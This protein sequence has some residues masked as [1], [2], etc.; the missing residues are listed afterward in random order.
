MRRKS[1][2]N[3]NLSKNN[4]KHQ[5]KI[6]MAKLKL[7][8]TAITD[9]G[10]IRKNNEDNFVV[11]QD[12]TGGNWF[13]PQADAAPFELGKFGSLMVVAD[14]MGGMNAGEVASDIAV[15]TVQEYF[16]ADKLSKEL[17]DDATAVNNYLKQVIMEADNRI[18][19]RSKSDP[20]TEGMGTTI[21]ITWIIGDMA[22]VAWCGDS[23]AYSYHPNSGLRQL[24]KDHSY[25]QELVDSGKL[26]PELAFD[27]PDGNIITSSLGDMS[28]PAAPDVV[29][30]ELHEGEIIL[31]C[32]D[33]LCGM[34]RDS[35]MLQVLDA[36]Y[37]DLTL[38]KKTL[39]DGALAAGGHDNVTL[40][41]TLVVK[42]GGKMP[43]TRDAD[44]AGAVNLPARPNRMKSLIAGGIIL[45]LLAIIGV[46][47]L[48][49]HNNKKDVPA[50]KTEVVDSVA[51]SKPDV[52]KATVKQDTANTKKPT[53]G[54]IRERIEQRIGDKQSK[55]DPDGSNH[56]AE[57]TPT[58]KLTPVA[59]KGDNKGGE[60]ENPEPIKEK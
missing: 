22:H 43:F 45:V 15:K 25:V 2:K 4:P 44:E 46:L 17:V 3:C 37:P 1:L 16:A 19:A 53:Q 11:C 8:L 14:G 13:V 40:A 23:R 32:S 9:V 36:H 48:K 54:K 26:K 35:E 24:S 31:L 5:E 12:L 30:T 51:T 21:V 41:M 56:D 42:G 55:Q 7:R 38:C 59:K 57:L 10:N 39:I 49:L 29:T 20:E 28:K 52:D 60:E 34:L 6:N 50:D 33:G 47:V 58:D 18:K 27:H